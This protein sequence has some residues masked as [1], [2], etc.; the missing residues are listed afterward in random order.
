MSTRRAAPRK[1][2][3]IGQALQGLTDG[4]YDMFSARLDLVRYEVIDEV[5]QTGQWG[6]IVLGGA[7]VL[8]LGY[9][10]LNLAVVLLVGALSGLM[11]P[12]ALTTAVLAVLHLAAG[13]V[14]L[15]HG[16]QRMTAYKF[17]LEMTRDEFQRD[18]QWLKEIGSTQETVEEVALET[19]SG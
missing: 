9:G 18:R 6:A 13:A 1:E 5:R 4:L 17:A 8:V 11:W 15:R 16:L 2:N 14:I 12:M 3:T 19:R 7:T 10:L